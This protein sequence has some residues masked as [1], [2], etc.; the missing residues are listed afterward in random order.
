[1]QGFQHIWRDIKRG[2]NLDLYVTI[3]V[4]VSLVVFNVVGNVSQPLIDSLTL[5]I[6]ALLATV[7]LGNRHRLEAIHRSL[8]MAGRR[9][10]LTQFPP[11]FKADIGRAT[12]LWL[13][14]T[15]LDDILTEYYS[16]FEK[17]LEGKSSIRALVLS[18]DGNACK[19]S[20][21]RFS[22][23]V[24]VE[25]ERALVQSTLARLRK[26]QE[27]A[28]G[29]LEVRIMDYLFSYEMILINPGKADGTIYLKWYNFHVLGGPSKPKLV[30]RPE[31]EE[32]YE[33]FHSEARN[34]WERA[35]LWNHQK[36]TQLDQQ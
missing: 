3:F 8:T 29:K 19:M 31:D 35:K 27:G 12:E 16:M 13:I 34:F 6:L 14:G 21:M 20:A 17:K 10:L 30:Y 2:E 36:L 23:Q 28:P 22:G 33:F 26:L 5:T 25:R 4:A 7:L 9:L 24:N 32:W 1:M 11:E 18:P 15:H